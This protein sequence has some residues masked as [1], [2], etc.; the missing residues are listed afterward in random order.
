MSI[1]E[2]EKTDHAKRLAAVA[3]FVEGM[4]EKMGYGSQR[5]TTRLSMAK[6]W[7]EAAEEG[8]IPTA[9]IV[10]KDGKIAWIGYPWG[11]LDQALEQTVAGTLR[12]QG[13]AG[14]GGGTAEASG[15]PRIRSRRCSSP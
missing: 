4:G 5:M 3:K 8:G 11:G 2:T 13:R 15:R 14:R 12:S 9:F 10:G 1:W 6:N 7:M